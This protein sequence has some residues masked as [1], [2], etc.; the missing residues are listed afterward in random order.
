MIAPAMLILQA[1]RLE[2]KIQDL[3]EEEPYTIVDFCG[4]CGHVG[5]VLAE[6]VPDC[7]VIICDIRP[8]SLAIAQDR[9]KAVKVQNVEL[10]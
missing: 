8:Q 3:S 9:I 7:K 4:G 2:G 1:A 6:M 10:W 5:L